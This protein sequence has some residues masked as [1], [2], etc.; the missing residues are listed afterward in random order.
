[1]SLDRAPVPLPGPDAPTQDGA[2]ALTRAGVLKMIGAGAA[3]AAGLTLLTDNSAFAA[4]PK[5]TKTDLAILQY[6]LTLEYLGS[7]FYESALKNANLSGKAK[8]V[9]IAF[10]GHELAHVAFVKKTITMLGG[11]PHAEQTFDFGSATRL[12]GRVPQDVDEDRGR[13]ASRRSTALAACLKASPDR[14]LRAR[15]RWRLV[16]RPG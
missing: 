1:M 16:R 3:G 11:T 10:R 9:A 7:S 15:P 14:R 5:S 12:A 8:Q 4:A 13:C 6:A 2:G